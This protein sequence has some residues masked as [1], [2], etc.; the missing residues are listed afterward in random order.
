MMA[1]TAPIDRT[2]SGSELQRSTCRVVRRLDIC[3]HNASQATYG[4]KKDELSSEHCSRSFQMLPWSVASQSKYFDAG[5]DKA[6]IMVARQKYARVF[7]SIPTKY[8][9]CS[10]DKP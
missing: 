10:H 8:M 9:V 7:T 6:M 4:E 3:Y 5:G 2:H 1:N